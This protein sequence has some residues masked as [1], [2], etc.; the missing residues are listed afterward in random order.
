M[1]GAMEGEWVT[2]LFGEDFACSICVDLGFLET[3]YLLEVL[4][5]LKNR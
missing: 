1:E 3:L 4:P 2:R 5:H